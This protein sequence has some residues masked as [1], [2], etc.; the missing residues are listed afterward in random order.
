MGHHARPLPS[1]HLF[2]TNVCGDGGPCG[3]GED[4]DQARRVVLWRNS[5]GTTPLVCAAK[6]GYADCV[7][8]LL[9]MALGAAL[10]WAIAVA[11]M[12]MPDLP[13]FNEMGGES[14]RVSQDKE[15]QYKKCPGDAPRQAGSDR[16][17]LWRPHAVTPMVCRRDL[18]NRAHRS[19]CRLRARRC[20]NRACDDSRLNNLSD[21]LVPRAVRRA[22]HSHIDHQYDLPP[23]RMLSM[24]WLRKW[25]TSMNHS[26]WFYVKTVVFGPTMALVGLACSYEESRA[27][28]VITTGDRL[29]ICYWPILFIGAHA[30]TIAHFAGEFLVTIPFLFMPPSDSDYERAK[31][32]ARMKSGFVLPF[33]CIVLPVILLHAS[34]EG[35]VSS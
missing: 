15:R 2:A 18:P 17:K 32:Y 27:T 19:G 3:H 4:S 5:S 23:A 26:I 6:Q 30:A 25:Q 33:A 14:L 12:E 13:G 31:E 8:V 7:E 20:R 10:E 35:G 28:D 22:C 21:L 16:S 24:R 1:R 29:L 34:R 9:R 11:M